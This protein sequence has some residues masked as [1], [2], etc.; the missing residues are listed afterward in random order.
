M[1]RTSLKLQE[2][3]AADL[4]LLCTRHAQ[5][6]NEFLMRLEQSGKPDDLQ[7]IKKISGR[8]MGEIYVAALYPIFESYPHL[9][10]SGFP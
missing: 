7:A 2:A 3:T 5:E 8:I 6:L 1:S 10:P 9:K 4:A